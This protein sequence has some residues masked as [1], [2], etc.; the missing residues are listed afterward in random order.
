[1]Q[2]GVRLVLYSLLMGS[3]MAKSTRS[4]HRRKPAALWI[5]RFPWCRDL[6]DGT[7]LQL[8]PGGQTAGS[9]GYPHQLRS[10]HLI[11]DQERFIQFIQRAWEIP[12][13]ESDLNVLEYHGLVMPIRKACTRSIMQ[14]AESGF[15][16][17]G[18][19]QYHPIQ[20]WMHA[21]W[22]YSKRSVP[23]SER[24]ERFVY[25][26][27]DTSGPL[28]T[29]IIAALRPTP[30]LFNGVWIPP[31]SIRPDSMHRRKKVRMARASSPEPDNCS[32]GT[33]ISA[34][35]LGCRGMWFRPLQPE[36]WAL[37]AS[38]LDHLHKPESRAADWIRR[39]LP[40]GLVSA[41]SITS[42]EAA[43]GN[44]G[45]TRFYVI[46]C[47]S[48]SQSRRNL[49]DG[50]FGMRL[51]QDHFVAYIVSRLRS[52]APLAAA[53]AMERAF[54]S[55]GV[56]TR[57]RVIEEFVETWQRTSAITELSLPAIVPNF[58]RN[59]LLW[60]LYQ[61]RGDITANQ[62]LKDL[63][64]LVGLKPDSVKQACWSGRRS[65]AVK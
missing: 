49:R 15:G 56:N 59:V 41:L 11:V 64:R 8:P 62:A 9:F 17:S 25:V 7:I 10:E 6:H 36:Y 48:H 63:G 51:G 22:C 39:S 13:T 57:R 50:H 46:G 31:Q 52:R 27:I 23:K 4:L 38:G 43:S 37:L 3:S 40:N 60:L 32:R 42:S 65:L 19:Q 61:N 14:V 30:F 12:L 34:S 26:P 21:R 1:M 45:V 24:N 58:H 44:A 35:S 55:R 54:Q 5:Q 20:Q 47:G 18:T 33:V 29:E 2:H 16:E 53:V 28:L